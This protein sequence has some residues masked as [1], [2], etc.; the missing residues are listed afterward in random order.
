MSVW[1]LSYFNYLDR[2]NYSEGLISKTSDLALLLEN[3]FTSTFWGL[4]ILVIS[5]GTIFSIIA[6]IYRDH[7]FQ[8]MTSLMWV[9]ILILSIN[10]KDTLKNNI[11]SLFIILPILIFN[12]VAF[13]DQKK[14]S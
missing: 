4:L 14:Y 12:F 5:L 13:Y 3:M 7:K 11:S 10:V 1:Y 8:L 9:I 6:F 2:L